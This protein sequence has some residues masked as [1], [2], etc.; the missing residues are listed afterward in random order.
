MTQNDR[1]KTLIITFL[2]LWVCWAIC[3][4]PYAV[5]E[6]FVVIS[7]RPALV[8]SMVALKQRTI[9][10]TNTATSISNSMQVETLLLSVKQLFGL[11]NS[12]IL[13]VLVKPFRLPLQKLI[14]GISARTCKK[15]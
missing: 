1:K 4:L 14:G 3:N 11:L 12:L 9:W 10:Y 6:T 2:T 7:D 13:L 5:Y 8:R 15:P